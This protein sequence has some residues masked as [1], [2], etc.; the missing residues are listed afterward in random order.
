[1][2]AIGLYSIAAVGSKNFYQN[3]F[4]SFAFII[5]CIAF[6]ISPGVAPLSAMSIILSAYS[7]DS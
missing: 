2:G 1:M 4:P 5:S 7:L 3:W 6:S